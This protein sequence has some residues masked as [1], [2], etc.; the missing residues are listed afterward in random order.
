MCSLSNSAQ[1]LEPWLAE[2][3]ARNALLE[4]FA[5]IDAM[6][7]AEYARWLT[8][9]DLRVSWETLH[10]LWLLGVVRPIAVLSPALVQLQGLAPTRFQQIDLG[11]DVESFIDLGVEPPVEDRLVSIPS[12]FDNE[13]SDSL[14]WHPFQLWPVLRL[15]QVLV[16]QPSLN[17]VRYSAE[18]TVHMAGRDA[19]ARATLLRSV[20]NNLAHSSFEK[21]LLLLIRAE[22]LVHDRLTHLVSLPIG[23]TIGDFEGWRDAQDGAAI[24]GQIGMALPEIQDWHR[25]ISL[26]AITLDPIKHFRPL[27]R[28][29]SHEQREKLEGKAQLADTLYQFGEILRSYVHRFLEASLLEEDDAFQGAEGPAIKERLFGAAGV[30]NADRSVRRRIVR[31]FGVDP[32]ARARWFIEGPTEEGFL[33]HLAERL[34][35]DLFEAGLEL[36][37]LRGIGNIQSHLVRD[38]LELLKREQIFAYVS[39]DDDGGGEHLRALRR[40]TTDGLLTAGFRVWSPDFEDENFERSELALAASNRARAEG[41]DVELT[42]SELGERDIS[43]YPAERVPVGKRI[44]KLW[45]EK[46]KYNGGK[47]AEWGAALADLVF[48][49]EGPRLLQLPSTSNR[50]VIRT[51]ATLLRSDS[52]DFDTTA[53]LLKVTSSGEL[54]RR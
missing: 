34:G 32:Q 15:F 7:T 24:I 21:L 43:R 33:R 36:V 3:I 53:K 10:H 18:Q 49:C 31:M 38:S 50:P 23:A 9:R 48:E 17:S 52:F 28:Q 45:W 41:F 42:A 6:N 19:S 2:Q 54:V 44:E 5:Q 40:Y 47:G 20:W 8:R 29:I 35:V 27:F 51:L 22:P 25:S 11:F 13:L 26:T 39:L 46:A 1:P 12:T 30:S 16:E 14:L 4:P 37:N